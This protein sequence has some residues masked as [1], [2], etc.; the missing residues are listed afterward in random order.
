MGHDPYST[1]IICSGGGGLSKEYIAKIQKAGWA[2]SEHLSYQDNINLDVLLRT[3]HVAPRRTFICKGCK[4]LFIKQASGKRQ[5]Y[6]GPCSYERHLE[7]ERK[8]NLRKKMKM[9]NGGDGT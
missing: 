2:Q 7:V 9:Q 8:R 3:E 5:D 6:C 4:N 1:D